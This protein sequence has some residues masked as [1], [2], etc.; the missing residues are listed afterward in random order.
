MPGFEYS[1]PLPY[2]QPSFIFEGDQ[3]FLGAPYVDCVNNHYTTI[4]P[5]FEAA[6]TAFGPE[7]SPE[8]Q[9]CGRRMLSGQFWLDDLIDTNTVGR[10][11]Y[12]NIIRALPTGGELPDD[13]PPL[14]PELKTSVALLHNAM[15]PL[16]DE[17]QE[18][19]VEDGIK[20]YDLTAEQMVATSM[21]IYSRI[22]VAKP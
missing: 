19:I 6:A 13:L 21:H 18:H 3:T 7:L 9:E 1:T 10:A 22:G 8:A 20:I 15:R 16:P 5:A 4:M 12:E 14:K 11:T 2:E 17:A